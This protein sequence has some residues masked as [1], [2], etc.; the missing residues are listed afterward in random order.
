MPIGCL[1]IAKVAERGA[2]RGDVSVQLSSECLG[3]IREQE[4]NS[5]PTRAM[6]KV[7]AVIR[8]YRSAS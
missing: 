3:P 8:A 2:K 4:D 7:K 5:A 1:E 6:H